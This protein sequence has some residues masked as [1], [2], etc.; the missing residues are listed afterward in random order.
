MTDAASI[1]FGRRLPP[2]T[3]LEGL[4]RHAL[5]GTQN[6]RT[7]GLEG[8]K[9]MKSLAI[10]DTE[11]SDLDPANGSLLEIACAIW[12][13]DSRSVAKTSSCLV[14]ADSNAAENVNRIPV[15]ALQ[16]ADPRDVVMRRVVPWL[17]NAKPD[18]IVAHNA[19]FDRKWL[20]E[21]HGFPWVCSCHD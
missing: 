18:A 1:Q 20:P 17:G 21:L 16:L 11:T 5:S 14:R 13:V 12:L 9:E 10:I 7:N 15:A 6:P 8:K 19:E 3:G 4:S 2:H